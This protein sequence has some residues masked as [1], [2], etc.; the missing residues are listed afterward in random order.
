[1]KV[2]I[3]TKKF[4]NGLFY[5][6]L[7]ILLDRT[8][9]LTIISGTPFF[10][11][12]SRIAT[13]VVIFGCLFF[14]RSIVIYDIV[15]AT[16]G[17]LI[18]TLAITILNYNSVWT[19]ISA[20]Y[21]ILGMC[22]LMILTSTSIQRRHNFVKA[23]SN[24]Y[25]FM[26]SINLF[27]IIFFPDLFG[28]KYLMGLENQIGYTLIIGELFVYLNHLFSDSR[29]KLI[30]YNIVTVSTLVII[31]SGSNLVGMSIFVLYIFI[32]PFRSF[33]KDHNLGWFLIIYLAV[34]VSIVL[35]A[36]DD[37]LNFPLI[38]Y[39]IED[40]LGKNV[41][42]T[43]RTYIWQVASAAFLK[44]PWLGHGIADTTNIFYIHKE[45]TSR[46]TI[47]AYYSAHNQILQ[48]LYEIGIIGI[49]IV[50]ILLLIADKNLKKCK[51][52]DIRGIFRIA[53]IVTMVMMLAEAPGLNSL[54]F[55]LNFSSI[56]SQKYTSE[57]KGQM[58]YGL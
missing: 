2:K 47:D 50:A 14:N 52:D 12:A 36:K 51:N 44:K 18:Y 6:L 29:K 11:L 41:T 54:I 21:P 27:F 55:I 10:A 40:I 28:N 34:W 32:S 3:N 24:L 9:E 35:L 38:K 16:A 53:I 19:A 22:A 58:V 25:V 57:Q 39:I 7:F 31:F 15:V 5:C 37:I 20:I 49:G 30:Y 46:A 17:Y 56:I 48:S 8:M 1:M 33:V 45:F 42:L 23:I 26:S 43:S 4:K 13:I